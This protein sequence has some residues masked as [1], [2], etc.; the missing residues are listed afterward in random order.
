[1][2]DEIFIT[3]CSGAEAEKGKVNA[4]LKP[5]PLGARLQTPKT[6]SA[7]RVKGQAVLA[8]AIAYKLSLFR[9]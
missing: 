3:F 2:T 6:F 8:S 4:G 7:D 5:R 1:M 9:L